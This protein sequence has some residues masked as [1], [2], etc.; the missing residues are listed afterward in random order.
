VIV[1]LYG[2]N[3]LAIKRR[4][5]ILKALAD[6]GS[7]MLESNLNAIDGRDAKPNDIL[8]PAMSVPFLSAR[9]LVIV[10]HFLERFEPRADQRTPR[11]TAPFEALFAALDAGIPETTILVFLGLPFLAAQLKMAVTAK[12]PMVSRLAKIPGVLVEEKPALKTGQLIDAIREEAHERGVRFRPGQPAERLLPGEIMPREADP[13]ALIA[14]LLQGDMLSVANELDKL[15]LY[16]NG[17]D[18]TVVEVNRVCAGERV[19]TGFEFVDAV[20][21]GDLSKALEALVR[22]KRDGENLQGLMGLLLNGYRRSATIID[23]LD[24]KAAPEEIGK[25]MGRAGAFPKLRDAAI[26]RARGLGHAG[27]KSAY[28]ALVE[29]ERSFKQGE[30]DEE[31]AFEI[32]V[33]R[34][35]SLAGGGFA[36]ARRR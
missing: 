5:L 33:M 36:G 12:N 15:A 28:E 35:A 7:G 2:A 24:E 8:A 26:A 10:E 18:V 4:L 17:A 11:S 34:L 25:A 20:M 22:L 19:S 1:L 16:S 27:L 31:V 14:S 6:G 13:A 21:D 29:S 9:R 23:L 32:L 30:V 3:E